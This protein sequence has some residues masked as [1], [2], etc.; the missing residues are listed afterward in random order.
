V[1]EGNDLL[2]FARIHRPVFQ[3]KPDAIKLVMG[4]VAHKKGQHM[5]QTTNTGEATTPKLGEH[6]ALAHGLIP[7]LIRA[8]ASDDKMTR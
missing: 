7:L 5:A 6:F 4:G 3:I 8:G 2:H 1:T